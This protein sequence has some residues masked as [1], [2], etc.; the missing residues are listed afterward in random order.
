[1]TVR[2]INFG[3]SVLIEDSSRNPNFDH[4]LWLLRSSYQ[5]VLNMLGQA[6]LSTTHK[7]DTVQLVWRLRFHQDN[8]YTK[9]VVTTQR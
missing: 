5:T 4:Q 8:N 1:M 6:V 2:N 9:T 7:E 3:M